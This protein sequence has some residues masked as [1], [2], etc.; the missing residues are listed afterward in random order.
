MA[1]STLRAVILAG[2]I[3]VGFLGLTKLFPSNASI[4]VTPTASHAS[5]PSTTLHPSGSP[6]GSASPTAKPRKNSK[7]SVLVLN[8]TATTGLAAGVTTTLQND[9]YKTRTPADFPGA[10]QD[11]TIVYYQPGFQPEA[12]KLLGKYFP[13]GRLEQAPSS[14]PVDVDLEVVLG[15]DAA[16]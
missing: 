15:A 8:A 5:N 12:Q 4:G 10:D 1:T 3:V 7:V 13:T 11:Q 6:T 2:L 9:H 14:V 16:S